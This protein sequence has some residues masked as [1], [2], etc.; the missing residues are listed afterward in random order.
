MRVLPPASIPAKQFYKDISILKKYATLGNLLDIFV[1]PTC[2]AYCFTEKG[3]LLTIPLIDKS[4]IQLIDDIADSMQSVDINKV[5]NHYSICIAHDKYYI[6]ILSRIKEPLIPA[7]ENKEYIKLTIKAHKPQ[8]FIIRFTKYNNYLLSTYNERIAVYG[9]RPED[10]KLDLKL[11]S[12]MVPRENM[13]GLDQSRTPVMPSYNNESFFYYLHKTDINEN[14]LLAYDVRQVKIENEVISSRAIFQVKVDNLIK[15][16]EWSSTLNKLAIL[17]YSNEVIVIVVGEI[18][19]ILESELNSKECS[20][21]QRYSHK[22]ESG[23]T[24]MTL[25][26]IDN[27]CL[28]IA[29]A[30]DG[31]VLIFDPHLTLLSLQCN[32]LFINPKVS[33]NNHTIIAKRPLSYYKEHFLI[34]GNLISNL[35][36]YKLGFI[37]LRKDNKLTEYLMVSNYLENGKLGA[38]LKLV[39]VIE[40]SNIF[41][42]SFIHLFNYLMRRTKL[43]A[44][45]IILK[46]LKDILNIRSHYLFEFLSDYFSQLGYRL[47]TDDYYEEAYDI[48]VQVQSHA[49]M[50]AIEQY[51]RWKG[52]L[53]MTEKARKEAAKYEEGKRLIIQDKYKKLENLSKED[54]QRVMN[55]YHSLMNIENINELDLS[56]FDSW[57]INFEQY[58]TA[59]DL[60]LKGDYEKAAILY[61]NNKLEADAKRAETLNKLSKEDKVIEFIKPTKI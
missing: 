55:E 13:E 45:P 34:L 49:L 18:I 1:L 29:I 5:E 43:L 8:P 35:V 9:L 53:I 17:L 2:I 23:I 4:P 51:S 36:V 31:R 24:L 41:I 44:N 15:Y 19:N 61:K 12:V 26:W 58:E 30:A 14:S 25:H 47:L 40:D 46:Q 56:Q 21:I 50:K 33:L 22:F 57:N 48:A 39:K 20:D 37:T 60:E 10:E 28:L 32:Q 3:Y 52:R 16:Y 7:I 6:T 38:V 59:L 27:G 54:T 42:R 11:K